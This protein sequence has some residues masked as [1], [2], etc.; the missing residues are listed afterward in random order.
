MIK[1]TTSSTK[2][3]VIGSQKDILSKIHNMDNDESDDSDED[4]ELPAH[5]IENKDQLSPI[6]YILDKT[7]YRNKN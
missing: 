3:K 5:I 6:S 4:D 1:V 2:V 7:V